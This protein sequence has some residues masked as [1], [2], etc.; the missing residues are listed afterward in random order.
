MKSHHA[1]DSASEERN[2]RSTLDLGGHAKDLELSARNS[3]RPCLPSCFH[4][5]NPALAPTSPYAEWDDLSP[6]WPGHSCLSPG[7]LQ[8]PF[9]LVFCFCL[10]PSSTLNTDAFPSWTTH[11]PFH[12]PSSAHLLDGCCFMP[13]TCLHRTP[14]RPAVA[15]LV[16]CLPKP[17]ASLSAVPLWPGKLPG[18]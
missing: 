10:I 15:P 16:L 11:P 1:Q 5:P 14:R 13:F 4:T 8:E 3:C 7:L 12:H 2:H 6:P 9:K 18:H 17:L